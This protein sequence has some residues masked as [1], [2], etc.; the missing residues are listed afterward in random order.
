MQQ[1]VQPHAD[2]LMRQG[3]A[4]LQANDKA[5]AYDLL[6]QALQLVPHNEQAWLW[7]SG[8][9]ETDAERRYCLEQVLVINPRNAA[10]QRGM[11]LLPA[12]LPVSPFPEPEPPPLPVP[13][14]VPAP[15]PPPAAAA[16]S[17][18]H[19]SEAD[20]LLGLIMQ[21]DPPAGDRAPSPVLTTVATDRTASASNVLG[22]ALTSPYFETQAASSNVATLGRA[23]VAEPPRQ[24]PP[25]PLAVGGYAREVVDFVVREYGRHRSRDEII[26][27]LSEQHR[28][29]WNDAQEL[30]SKVEQDHRKTIAVRQSPFFVFLGIATIIGGCIMAGRA[31]F[32][33]YYAYNNA[34]ELGALG[35]I[36]NPRAIGFAVGQLITGIAMVL[37]A[38]IGLGQT[39]KEL[40]K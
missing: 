29:A 16:P 2:L 12:L 25:A 1:A 3:I 37:G 34:T 24:E 19:A 13:E 22:L 39:I 23:A 32:L 18:V 31:G 26:R 36:P 40:F 15:A 30:M 28:L 9:V 17:A 27:A 8:A 5:R 21:P 14:P 20:S 10:A 11:A 33:L 38:T 4:A 6:G 7:L 35:A